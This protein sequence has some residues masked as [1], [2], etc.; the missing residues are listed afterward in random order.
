MTQNRLA[1]QKM[2]KIIKDLY[3]H[4]MLITVPEGHFWKHIEES[5]KLKKAMALTI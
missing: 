4:H 2:A 5:P 1:N 3:H